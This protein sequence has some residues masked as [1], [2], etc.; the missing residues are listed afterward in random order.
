MSRNIMDGEIAGWRHELKDLEEAIS[1]EDP[2]LAPRTRA[3]AEAK[4]GTLQRPVSG[5]KHQ[6]AE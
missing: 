4:I 5:D 3:I 6:P 1:W 2:P